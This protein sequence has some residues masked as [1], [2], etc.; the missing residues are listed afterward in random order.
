[1][2]CS[3]TR[4]SLQLI[5]AIFRAQEI[6]NKLRTLIFLRDSKIIGAIQKPQPTYIVKNA[7]KQIK[8]SICT[9]KPC[10]G[11]SLGACTL[12][13]KMNLTARPIIENLLYAGKISLRTFLLSSK[14]QESVM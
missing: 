5:P 2:P 8:Y 4:I 11:Q 1:M 9:P 14:K 10:P 12:T 13:L 7:L 6:A 3:E